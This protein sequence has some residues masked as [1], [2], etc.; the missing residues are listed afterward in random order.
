[1][2]CNYSAKVIYFQCTVMEMSNID[3]MVSFGTM[4]II[5]P[6]LTL[7]KRND[8]SEHFTARQSKHSRYIKNKKTQ[9]HINV[10]HWGYC[11]IEWIDG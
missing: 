10:I 11:K 9:S 6:K 1:M 2:Q 3:V 4:G 8:G 5:F 7:T